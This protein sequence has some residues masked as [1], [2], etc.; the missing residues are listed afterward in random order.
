M[1]VW[2]SIRNSFRS[3]MNETQR[4]WWEHKRQKGVFVYILVDGMLFFGGWMFF[5]T[6]ASEHF[7]F[8][9]PINPYLIYEKAFS[10]LLAGLLF[11]IITGIINESR[12]A[13]AKTLCISDDSSKDSTT[14]KDEAH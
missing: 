5:V 8:H 6:L 7:I 13:R 14:N 2:S 11:G 1:S 10:S 3:S 9:R 4:S 12:Y